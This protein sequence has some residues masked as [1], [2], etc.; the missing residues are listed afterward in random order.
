MMKNKEQEIIDKTEEYYLP[1]FKRNKLVFDHG[2]GCYLYDVNGK[3]YLDF[4]AG[5]AVNAFGYNY[6]KLV[7]AISEQAGKIMHCSNY[8]YTEVQA[9]AV[10]LIA[11]ITK[12]DKVFL[13]NSGA[14]ANEGALKLAR[15]Y[16][17]KKNVNKYKIISAVHSF[18]GRTIATLTATGQPHYQE[19]FAPLPTGYEYV[20]YGDLEALKAKMD[21]TVC[22][23][24][25]EP[26]QGEGGVNVP[27][28]GYLQAVRKICDENEAL[29][30]FDEIQC[31]MARSGKW[32]AWEHENVKPD[33]ITLAKAIGGGFPMGAFCVSEK[34]ANVL[35][36]GD[37]GS[38][39]GGNPLSCAA[40]K[41][42]ISEMKALDMPNKVTE[43]G[44]Y[45]KA[46]LMKLKGKYPE[47]I[48][49]VRG[50][51]L[52]LGMEVNKSGADIVTAALDKGLIINCTAECVIRL[53]PPLIVSKKQM[54]TALSILDEVLETF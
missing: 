24:L 22:A 2:E 36:Y 42:T 28:K 26:I 40:V 49:E 6:K 9:D 21:E 20:P 25:L 53:V 29:V 32:F 8:F 19:G 44:E 14:E 38:T 16:G 4:L 17:Y 3:E 31:G 47:K 23:V 35:T 30:M 12:M 43:K 45:L 50:K 41:A 33:V 54:D 5:I 51:G 10:E 52:M 37:H 27:P 11:E 15:K 48:K 46:G 7:D 13:C 34:Y 18:H 39:F 1:V